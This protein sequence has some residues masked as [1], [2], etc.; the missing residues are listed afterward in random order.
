MHESGKCVYFGHSDF[1]HA[2]V[3]KHTGAVVHLLIVSNDL[4]GGLF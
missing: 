2:D 3:L 1:N 4:V